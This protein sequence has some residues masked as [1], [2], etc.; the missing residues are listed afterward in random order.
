MKDIK[1]GNVR[2]C[3][4][5]CCMGQN[6]GLSNS[7]KGDGCGAHANEYQYTS[8]RYLCI[9]SQ[10]APGCNSTIYKCNSICGGT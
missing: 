5:I 9:V 8:I 7:K 6:G 3:Y 4:R 2:K 10:Q 1:N